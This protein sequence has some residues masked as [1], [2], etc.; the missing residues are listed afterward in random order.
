MAFSAANLDGE[1]SAWGGIRVGVVGTFGKRLVERVRARR[2][3]LERPFRCARAL[4]EAVGGRRRADLEGVF[5]MVVICSR[6]VQNIE[7]L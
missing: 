6:A 7:Y 5:L 3:R 1:H 2:P 4:R